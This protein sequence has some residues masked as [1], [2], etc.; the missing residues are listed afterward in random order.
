MDDEILIDAPLT[1]TN[2]VSF[3]N[4]MKLRYNDG[5]GTRDVV[6]FMGADF[7]D[8]MQIKCNI[9][10]S[11]DSTI[12]VDPET[13]NFLENPDI[14]SIPQTSEDYCREITTVDPSDVEHLLKPQSISPLQEEMMSYHY[15]LHHM[16]FP[17]MIVLAEKG[18]LPKRLSSLKGRCPICVAC[19]FGQAHKRPWRSKSKQ[20]HPI[21]KPSDNAPG[22]RTSVDQ[23]V[24]AQPGLIPQMSGSL[25]N[26][27]IMGATV[28]VDHFSDHTYVYLMRDL[29][30]AETLMA[31]HAYERFLASLGID[32][33]A[34]HADNGRFADKGF[35]DDCTHSNQI[36]TFCGVGGH[37][38]NGIAERKIKDITLG[39]R[40][41]L[42][43]AKRM[44]PEYISTILWPFAVKCYEDRM[45]NLTFRADG[46][47]PFE[48]LAGLDSSP[49][50]LANF[51]TFGCPCYV[52][53]HRLQSGAGKIPKWEPRSRM[54]IYVGRSPSHAANVS[55][56]LNPRTG[57][58]S[59]QFHVVYDDDFTTVPYLRTATV[60]PHWAALVAASVTIELYT[61]QQVGTWQSLPELEVESGDFTSDSSVVID[62]SEPTVNSEGAPHVTD[63]HDKD[64]VTNRVTFSDGRDNEIQ[65]MSRDES[66]PRP[67]DW[68]MP[69]QIDLDSSGLRRSTRTEVLRRRDK[70]YSHSTIKKIIQRSS[71]HACLVLFSSF[72]AIGA[73]LKCGVHPHQVLAASSSTLSNAVASYHRVNSLYDGTINCFSTLAQSSVASN[74]TFNYKEALQQ[75]DYHDF[76]K[77][78]IHE[79]DDHEQ[80][81]HWTLTKRCDLP[82][83]TKTILSIW[84]F[85]RKRYPDGTLNKH[86]AR[87]CAHGGMQTKLLGD[88]RTG[89]QLGECTNLTCDCENSWLVFKEH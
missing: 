18:V 30:L 60:P 81:A 28:F 1:L 59:P 5:S 47:T 87:L 79:V 67:N 88:L 58:I 15:R 56:I 20:K 84:S 78:M 42:L 4:G 85:K 17:Q 52:L 44:L 31:K 49:V 70:V 36:I 6:T 14:A 32:S 26:L 43:H 62:E 75:A 24:S 16:Q 48:T 46:R 22:K 51:H 82:P 34:Y 12:L 10:L 86:K 71:K 65:S 57:H 29:T 61:E 35:R 11:N 69:Q 25:T 83:G 19:L 8:G 39:G 80:R 54:G 77:A 55:L 37:H 53:D 23:L 2:L 45:N 72:C 73:G 63:A 89:R 9:K 7:V 33:K 68:Q 64:I 66:L 74:E 3:L 38:Q 27:R 76:V 40:T 13:L 50:I 21:R 41:L